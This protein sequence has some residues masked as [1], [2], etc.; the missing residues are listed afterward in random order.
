MASPARASQAPAAPA[1]PAPER[2]FEVVSVKENTT[3]DAS[4]YASIDLS[5]SANQ[6]SDP[7]QGIVTLRNIYLCNL[8][9]R[10][11]E[12]GVLQ[13]FGLLNAA[14]GDGI[15]VRGGSGSTG[16][17][18][19]RF[20]VV[21]RP[22]AGSRPGDVFAML[23]AML[24]ERFRLRIRRDVRPVP[25]YALVRVEEG[26]SGPRLTPS[27]LDCAEIVRQDPALEPKADDGLPV[28]RGRSRVS[29]RGTML[30][31]AGS[32]TALARGL[33]STAD[34]LVVDATGDSGRYAWSVDFSPM[35]VQDPP[36]PVLF[37]AVRE[38]LG[39][40]LEPRT[41]PVEVLVIEHVEAPTPD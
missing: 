11:H 12:M 21:A 18:A 7:I 16:V 38:Q 32:L 41:M 14:A 2:R 5:P 15:C 25:V 29:S 26:R 27:G 17:L 9:A 33:Q 19:R 35:A 6:A 4:G 40:K 22:P 23:R 20:D 31:S 10:A 37:T 39:L 1:P 8:I 30:R 36:F 28:C 24:A 3:A 34:R 13:R